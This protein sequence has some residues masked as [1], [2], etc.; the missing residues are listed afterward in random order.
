MLKAELHIHTS[1]DPAD[2]IPYSTDD[3]IDHAAGLGYQ[4]L[5][6]TLHNRQLDLRPFAAH[7]RERGIT[8]IPG[9][10]RTIRGKHVLLLNFPVEAERVNTLEEVAALKSRWPGLVIAPHPFYP[11]PNCL[12]RMLE[13]HAAVFD[14]VEYNYFYTR[15][16]NWFNEAAS[17]W[18]ARHGKPVVANSDVHRLKQLGRTY[19][20]V[21]AEP[22]AHAICTAI[23]AGR[24]ERRSEPIS[25][26][27]AAIHFTD[28]G[29]GGITGRLRPSHTPQRPATVG[30]LPITG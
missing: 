13:Q 5:A 2:A 28:I 23:R 16:M 19:S 3:L 1:D 24:V 18:A 12:G 11:A 27:A 25:P 26:W 8:L 22:D 7:A 30:Q 20:L 6:I 15:H 29:I 9:V 4:A 17:R 21:D 10:E 14:A